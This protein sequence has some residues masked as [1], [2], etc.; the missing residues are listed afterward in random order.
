MGESSSLERALDAS[1]GTREFYDRLASDYHAAILRCVP[2]YEHMLD[3]ILRY[4]PEDL[5]PRHILELGCG[6]GHL[7]R[8]V[9]ARFPDAEIV[10]LDHSAELL[11]VCDHTLDEGRFVGVRADFEGL[12]FTPGRFDLCVSSIA[13]HHVDDAA[14]QRLF[15]SVFEALRPDGVFAYSDQFRG[16]TAE[17]YAKHMESWK[18]EA[19]ALGATEGEWDAWMRHQERDDHHATL[20]DQVRWLEDAGFAPV[21]C[22]WRNLLW[23]VLVARRP[24]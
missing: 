24:R 4:V 8:R 10:G 23:T 1:T 21:D 9:L 12:P 2:C 20:R 22:V 18:R 3:T 19:F 13:I 15:A 11:R 7:T 5:R 6:S 17:I 16:E 14:K